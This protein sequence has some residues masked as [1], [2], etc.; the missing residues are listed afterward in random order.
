MSSWRRQVTK[1]L[2]EI[3]EVQSVGGGCIADA[4]VVT[5]VNGERIFVKTF[6]GKPDMFPKE[7]NGLRELR[8]AE[9]IKVP[10]VLAVGDDFLVL[11]HVGGGRPA[12]DFMET[13]GRQFAQMHRHHSDRCGLFEDNYCGNTVQKNTPQ[14]K[15][16]PTFYWENRLLF[17][18]QLAEKAGY[19]DRQMLDLFGKLENRLSDILA[20]SEE[21]PSILHGDLW[22][23]NYMT[24]PEGEPVLIDPAAYYG[25]READLGMTHL[26]GNFTRRF[27]DAYEE[28]YPLP[29]GADYRCGLYKLYHV[30]NHLNIFGMGYHGQAISLLRNYV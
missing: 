7:A 20:G 16:W 5:L 19:A 2:G 30:M 4:N 27:Y 23:G 12:A 17:Q 9:A 21:L 26:F 18:L 13:F 11:E 1:Q 3:A 29:D 14:L 10:D 22:S 28:A 25:H 6:A 15:D 24:G 8:Q